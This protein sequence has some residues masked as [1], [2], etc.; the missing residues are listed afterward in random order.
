MKS[1]HALH[2]LP[3]LA[4]GLILTGSLSGCG[5]NSGSNSGNNALEATSARQVR[6]AQKT[7]E[8]NPYA[9]LVQ[10]LYV[11]F[12]GR[13]ADPTGLANFETALANANAPENAQSLLQIYNTGTNPAVN[14]LVNSFGT[15]AES[16]AL[17]GN[18][19]TTQFVQAIFNNVLDRQPAQSGLDF[20]VDAIN[21]GQVTRG[22]ASLQIMEGALTNTTAQGLLDQTLINN[23][24]A[25]AMSFT[26]EIQ[27]AAELRGYAGATAAATARAML[28]TVTATT[29]LSS[30][31]TTVDSTVESLSRYLIG[32]TLSGLGSGATV[33]LLDNGGDALT[34]TANGTYDFATPLL[35]SDTFDVTVGTQPIGELCSVNGGSGSVVSDVTFANVSCHF[36]YAYAVNLSG[37]S[38]SQYA[39]QANGSLSI[40]ATP[41]VSTGKTPSSIVIGPGYQSVYV[42]NQ[43]DNSVSQFTIN[44]DGSLAT[45]APVTTQYEP[46][47]LAITPNGKYAYVANFGT[48]TVSQYNVQ[49]SGALTPQSSATVT[50]GTAPTGIA[51]DPTSSYVYVLNNGSE[52]VAQYT[53]NASG[54]LTPMAAPTVGTGGS[55]LAIGISP[56]GKYVYVVNNSASDRS[57]SQYSVGANG[58]LTPLSPAKISVGTSPSAIAFNPAGTNAYVVDTAGTVWQFSIGSGGALSQ[59]GSTSVTG[60]NAFAIDPSGRFAYAAIKTGTVAQF[61]VGSG[62]GLTA[63]SPATVAAGQT[64]FGIAVNF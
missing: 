57:V 62:G 41:S 51:I 22:S 25:V 15:S 3:A 27:T 12:F 7:A 55:P 9:T 40:D 36:P 24:I 60:V 33:I 42:T 4:L 59:V 34:L 31:A 26:S 28:A 63:M 52:T 6:G 48:T 11:S 30:F 50:S 47:A 18:G 54:A 14:S 1:P 64:P 32:G 16:Q 39:L 23:R 56:N 35:N 8:T 46:T 38:I 13:P 20:W 21:S 37:D 58:S 29:N 53:I 43:G 44:A 10:Q 49:S 61:A 2:L 17:Y 45:G 19:T 5:G